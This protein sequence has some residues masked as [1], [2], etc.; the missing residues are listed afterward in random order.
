[1]D[2]EERKQLE[3]LSKLV[4]GFNDFVHLEESGE[5]GALFP[6]QKDVDEDEEQ[7]HVETH[8]K[9]PEDG[10][11]QLNSEKFFEVMMESLGAFYF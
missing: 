4:G 8:Q 9:D 1:M 7:G 5:R 6:G 11:I 10:P 2:P 3:T